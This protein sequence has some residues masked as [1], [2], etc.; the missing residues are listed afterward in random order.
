MIFIKKYYIIYRHLDLG[1]NGVCF[2]DACVVYFIPPTDGEYAFSANEGVRITYFSYDSLRNEEVTAPLS[3]MAGEELRL[4]LQ[5]D[6]E[7]AATV[8]VTKK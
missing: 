7:A 5:T 1:E 2:T 6:G 8:T 3:L 4:V